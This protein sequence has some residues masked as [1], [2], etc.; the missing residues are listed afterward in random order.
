MFRYPGDCFMKLSY[1][2]ACRNFVRMALM[3]S[4]FI[5]CAN[6]YPENWFN[7]R[8]SSLDFVLNFDEIYFPPM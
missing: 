6:L 4:S 8:N 7:N 1:S 2:F 3:Y 5:A